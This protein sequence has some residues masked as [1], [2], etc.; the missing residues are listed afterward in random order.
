MRRGNLA[1]NPVGSDHV[2]NIQVFYRGRRECHKSSWVF[3]A[4]VTRHLRVS[5]G[6]G[7]DA[8]KSKVLGVLRKIVFLLLFFVEWL[9]IPLEKQL[10]TFALQLHEGLLLDL[11]FE[12]TLKLSAQG[13]SFSMEIV[14]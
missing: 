13:V 3:L 4:S 2:E 1:D 9:L 12:R 6:V 5:G 11:L 7:N 8:L 14:G 10:L